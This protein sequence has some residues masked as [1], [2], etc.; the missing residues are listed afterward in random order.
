MKLSSKSEKDNRSD[1]YCKDNL[2]N[3]CLTSGGCE[4]TDKCKYVNSGCG[5]LLLYECNGVCADEL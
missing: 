3:I 1:C 5:Y 2:I 4:K